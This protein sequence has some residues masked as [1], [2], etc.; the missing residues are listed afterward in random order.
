M[1]GFIKGLFGVKARE[2]NISESQ[3]TPPSASKADSKAFFLEP[4]DAKTFGDIDYMRSSKTVRRTFPKT[5]G[6]GGEFEQVKN[7][8]ATDLKATTG[9]GSIPKLSEPEVKPVIS[10]R[11]VE[12]SDRRTAD[13]SMEMFRRMA[14]N[15]KKP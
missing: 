9:E 11:P 14:R 13:P 4:D 5:K 8:S 2:G 10:E 3:G 7:V 15:A 12:A 1:V 6:N